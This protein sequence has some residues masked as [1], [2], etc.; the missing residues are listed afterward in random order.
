VLRSTG[1][2]FLERKSRSSRIHRP[3]FSNKNNLIQWAF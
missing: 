2:E 3:Y 1:N